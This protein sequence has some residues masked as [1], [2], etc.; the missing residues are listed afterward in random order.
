[1]KKIL[2]LS[3]THNY[4]DD[5]ILD[6]ASQSDYVI[7]AGDIGNYE[8]IDKLKSVSKLYHVY[9]NIDG[10]EVR[11]ES[12]EFLFFKIDNLKILLTHISGKS[13]NYNKKQLMRLQKLILIYL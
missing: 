2:V 6:F 4:L 5:R 9:G 10:T 11:S 7:H 13:P 3:D 8:I 12:N 1:M